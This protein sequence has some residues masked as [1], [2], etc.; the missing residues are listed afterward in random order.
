MKLETR[1]TVYKKKDSGVYSRLIAGSPDYH[2]DTIEVIISDTFRIFVHPQKPTDFR[3]F[4]RTP[5]RII[6]EIN[7]N[8]RNIQL[9]S[10]GYYSAWIPYE[11]EATNY[12]VY[13]EE[14]DIEKVKLKM[15]EKNKI[16]NSL[17]VIPKKGAVYNPSKDKPE[18]EYRKRAYYGK[19]KKW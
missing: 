3:K 9:F 11:Y 6:H 12:V 10:Y 5:E 1:I 15:E 18:M 14:S 8:R 16:R 7:K 13:L 4:K 17:N 2:I 19:C